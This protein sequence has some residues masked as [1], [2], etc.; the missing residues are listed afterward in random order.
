M[1]GLDNLLAD[2]EG[3]TVAPVASTPAPTSRGKS[4]G[5][6]VAAK[7]LTTLFRSPSAF[8]ASARFAT[9]GSEPTECFGLIGKDGRR[10]CLLKGCDKKHRGGT[11]DIPPNHLFIRNS[12]TEAFCSPCVDAAKVPPGQVAD[13]L[14]LSKP[15]TEWVDVFGVLESAEDELP[16]DEVERKL[17]FLSLARVHK[18]PRKAEPSSPSVFEG[19]DLNNMLESVPD[20]ILKGSEY[21]WSRDMPKDLV[22]ALEALGRTVTTLASTVPTALSESAIRAAREKKW[23]F[24]TCEQL[25]ARLI[26]IESTTGTRVEDDGDLPPTLWETVTSLWSRSPGGESPSQAEVGG[27]PTGRGNDQIVRA[28]ETVQNQYT[29]ARDASNA[30]AREVDEFKEKVNKLFGLATERLSDLVKVQ[31]Q[32]TSELNR[33]SKLVGSGGASAGSAGSG[34]GLDSL[35]ASLGGGGSDGGDDLNALRKEVAALREELRHAKDRSDEAVKIGGLQFETRE[36]LAAYLMEEAPGLPFG[37]IVDYHALMQQVHYDMG[38]Y[39]SSDS[40]LKGLKLRSDMALE[41]NADVLAL[42]S[43]RRGIPALLGE[44]KPATSKDR[45]S[46][47]AFHSFSDWKNNNG[48]DGL[49]H[50]LPSSQQHRPG[51]GSPGACRVWHSQTHLRYDG[52]RFRW[53][54]RVGVRRLARLDL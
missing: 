28:L 8:A 31:N 41:T 19:D 25:N 46:F 12:P 39:E 22:D 26:S 13:L 49:V 45:S 54:S 18:T 15:V 10:F 21:E 17:E 6:G 43:I 40:L 47:N 29:K 14:A 16:L 34:S 23:T 51:L 5:G 33:I 7:R 53:M 20:E 11:Y 3:L 30:T 37:T 1:S 38:G 52:L 42:A 50:T 9:E 36:D 32:T 2:M 48:R 4:T 24:D 27:L 44:G 35:L